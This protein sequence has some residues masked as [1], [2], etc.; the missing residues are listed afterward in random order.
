[1]CVEVPVI[2]DSYQ[3]VMTYLG[4]NMNPWFLETD[5]TLRQATAETLTPTLVAL[6]AVSKLLVH[7]GAV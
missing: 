3:N 6:Q 5:M 4:T 7:I 2:R 1:M